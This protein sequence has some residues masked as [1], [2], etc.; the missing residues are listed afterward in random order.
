M[1]DST[2]EEILDSLAV[3]QTQA[4]P[5][6][7]DEILREGKVTSMEL[8]HGLTLQI[9]ERQSDKITKFTK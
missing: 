2:S 4:S 1:S 6:N 8:E 3:A 9:S 7:S 5:V